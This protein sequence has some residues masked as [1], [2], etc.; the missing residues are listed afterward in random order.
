MVISLLLALD[1]GEIVRMKVVRADT[2][3]A[4]TVLAIEAIL[5]PIATVNGSGCKVNNRKLSFLS[6]RDHTLK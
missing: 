1:T 2:N 3:R 6:H 4:T 5:P